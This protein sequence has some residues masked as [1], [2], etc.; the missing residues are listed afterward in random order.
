M[1]ATREAINRVKIERAR[2]SK[3]PVDPDAIIYQGDCMVWDAANKRAAVGSAASAGTFMGI[4]ETT[5]PIETS[6]SPTFLS[7][8]KKGR[9]NVIQEALV[10]LIGTN[11]E[12]L[13]PFD[14]VTIGANAQTVVKSGATDANMVGVV[15]PSVG[16]TGKAVVT[17][18]LVKIWLRARPQ[19]AA[20]AQA[21][22]SAT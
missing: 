2:L 1:A 12:T 5:Q 14:Q 16:S 8:L 21:V 9:I 4:S 15:D 20:Q 7:N 19:Y 3:V 13:Y 10:E 22:D 6:G 18:D 11:G 17:G